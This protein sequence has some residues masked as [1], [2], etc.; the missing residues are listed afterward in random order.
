MNRGKWGN[1][2][3][4]VI[5]DK[6]IE[7]KRKRVELLPYPVVLAIYLNMCLSHTTTGEVGLFFSIINVGETV[8][9]I[10][11]FLCRM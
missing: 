7:A 6:A 9:Q 8:N 5:P 2:R 10:F 3:H 4:R 11:D 1:P